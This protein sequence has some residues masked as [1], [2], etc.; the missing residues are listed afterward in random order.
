M[1][2][3]DHTN[4]SDSFGVSRPRTQAAIQNAGKIHDRERTQTV[5]MDGGTVR[6]ADAPTPTDW[7]HLKILEVIGE[8]GFGEVYK[9]WDPTLE[10]SVALKL[11]HA[12]APEG[13]ALQSEGR[14]LAKLR[15]PNVVT[16][17][18]VAEHDGRAGLWE[19]FIRGRTLAQVVV[20]NGT[21]S[22]HEACSIGR[23]VCRAVAAVHGAGLI[24][25]D[26]KAQNVM[27]ED[28]GRI[29]LMD[30]GLGV[31]AATVAGIAQ[32]G[33]PAYMA[34]ELLS[35]GKASIQS[36]VYAVGVLLYNLVTGDYPVGGHSFAE[37]TDGHK[38]GRRKLLHDARPDLSENYVRTVERALA[39][40]PQRR[41]QTVGELLRALSEV[42]S[43]V[44]PAGP[45][46]IQKRRGYLIPAAL[47]LLT[48]AVSLGWW[49]MR[50][51]TAG[52]PDAGLESIAVLPFDNL[53]GSADNAYLADGIA[54]ELTNELTKSAKL[55]VVARSSATQF[56]LSNTNLSM[57]EVSRQLGVKSVLTGSIRRAGDRVRVA[58]RLIRVSDS[59]QLW[60]E[61]YEHELKDVFD[62]EQKISKAVAAALQVQLSPRPTG[63]AI[64]EAH[65]LLL[66]ARFLTN[67]GTNASSQQGL[68]TLKQAIK[69]SP[70][71]PEAH[72]LMARTYASIAAVNADAETVAKAKE[73]AGLALG[74][75][76]TNADAHVALGYVKELYDLDWKGA[77]QHF[78]LA[79]DF[80]PR[81]VDTRLL[82]AGLLINLGRTAEARAQ[83]AAAEAVDPLS[84]A[85]AWFRAALLNTEGRNAEAEVEVK[86]ALAERPEN[87][88]ARAI[89]A[90]I[91]WETGRM[92][93]AV[94][95]M[96]RAYELAP[97]PWMQSMLGF[98]LGQ[99]G[100]T[101]EAR[102]VLQELKGKA[103][104]G[105]AWPTHVATVYAGLN[106]RDNA[107]DW[108]GKAV[109]RHDPSLVRLKISPT[110]APLRGDARFKRMLA[111]VGLAN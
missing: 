90:L 71:Y 64:A 7:G 54:E 33:T 53:S 72:A 5:Y 23:E 4:D 42:D 100:A 77:E 37:L 50:D 82:Y 38:V 9:A 32:A 22:A 78:K 26:I 35:G 108:L 103:E 76:N 85:V 17:Y 28:G 47:L 48:A 101:G 96:K 46:V 19:E 87:A 6:R 41:F 62:V 70:N 2:P 20:E 75:D 1:A 10:R 16:V 52:L 27:R 81:Q 13:I 67:K 74:L 15:H 83:L 57:S 69:L 80:S 92:D 65:D 43:E 94:R 30:F 88:G 105:A 14:L 51:K 25:R 91:Y 36:D 86:K 55:R 61:T 63:R 95:E 18:G 49:L 31:D 99:S 24:H 68:E 84:S 40:E 34:P 12:N 58:A 107:F 56:K 3:A 45:E 44:V 89:L 79:V 21:F 11:L 97:N 110:F 104:R 8:G 29:V 73:S 98:V 93:D 66:R 59:T 106:E 102:Q 111:R 109:E 39:A 60:S